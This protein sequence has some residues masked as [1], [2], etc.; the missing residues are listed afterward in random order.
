VLAAAA[1]AELAE[2]EAQSRS[3][4]AQSGEPH[5]PWHSVDGW[6]LNAESHHDFNFVE[7][8]ANHAVRLRF[9]DTGLRLALDGKEHALQSKPLA[10]G[11]LELRIDG[12][13][14]KARAVR[15]GRDWHVFCEGAYRKLALKDELATVAED[16]GPGALNAPMPGRIVKLMTKPDAKVKKGE[17]LLILEAMKMEHTIAAPVDGTVKEIRYALGE[18]VLEGAELIRLE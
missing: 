12:R 14:V 4:S 6:R 16:A 1:I 15:H 18:Q 5:S 9:L 17:P 11:S 3:R 13:A 8:N 10:D 7:G 2:E